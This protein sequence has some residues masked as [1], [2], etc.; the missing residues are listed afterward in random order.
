MFGEARILLAPRR[1]NVLL[2]LIENEAVT[3]TVD[4]KLV[5]RR[6]HLGRERE[7]R[8][9]PLAVHDDDAQFVD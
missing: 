4:A 8:G 5:Q 1:I 9:C 3:A 7:I 6:S 2:V